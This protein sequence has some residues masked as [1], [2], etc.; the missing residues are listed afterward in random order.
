MRTKAALRSKRDKK[1]KTGGEVP[2][3][4]QLAADGVHLETNAKEQDAIFEAWKLKAE[5]HP[6][7][8][9]GIKLAGSGY[10]P[11]KGKAWHPQ[12]V[13]HLLSSEALKPPEERSCLGKS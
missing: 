7:R 2:Y 1:E 10:F 6:L 9:I 5:G 4:Y 13:K 8:E 12:T 11:R 3:G